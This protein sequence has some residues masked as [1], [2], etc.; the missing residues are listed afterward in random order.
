MP[1]LILA[2]GGHNG[3]DHWEP[4]LGYGL[5]IR[6]QLVHSFGLQLDYNGGTVKGGVSSNVPYITNTNGNR[7]KAFSTKFNQ[8]ALSGVFNFATVD[9]LRRKNAVQ[10]FLNAG[11]GVVYYEPTVTGYTDSSF[12]TASTSSFKSSA[13]VMPLGAGVKFRVSDAVAINLGYNENFIDASSFNGVNQYPKTSHYSYGYGGIEFSLG[14]KSKPH[15]QW[16]NPIVSIQNE[17]LTE[18]AR[19][20]RQIDAQKAANDQLRA[21]MAAA[22]AN[23]AKYTADSDGDG[24]S[25]FFDKCPGTPSGVKVDGAGCPLAVAPAPAPVTKVF[26]TEEDRKIVREAIRN[27]EFDFG[28]ATIRAHSFPSLN[29]VAQLLIDKNFSL[30]LAGHTD[31]VG[32]NDAN[33]KLSK[34]RAESVK[35]YLVDKGANASRIEATGYGETQPIATNKTAKGR[36]QNRRVEFTLF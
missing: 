35:N 11:L 14:A 31:N 3:F 2:T 20:Q 33:M 15:L 23:L 21:D 36:Q 8:V 28:K 5:S 25:D 1:S 32:S 13:L 12:P 26:V 22:T 16:A 10:F 19:L 7:Y 9:Y 29:R 34:A 17:Y 6:K 24:V 27:L 4:T 18:E 30:K